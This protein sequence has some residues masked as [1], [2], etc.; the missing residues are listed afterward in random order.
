MLE[1]DAVSAANCG[2]A[3]SSRVVSKPDSWSRIEEVTLHAAHGH[4]RGH[5]TLNNSVGQIADRR[6]SSIGC[7]KI[8][9]AIGIYAGLAG[10]VTR[11]IEV[12]SLFL[13]FPICPE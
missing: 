3:I 4:N 1:K 6:H 13:L 5:S 8:H 2:L 12:E 10:N 7:Q 9:G 11:W